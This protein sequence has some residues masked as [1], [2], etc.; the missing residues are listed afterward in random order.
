MRFG[1]ATIVAITAWCSATTSSAF[2]PTYHFSTIRTGRSEQSSHLVPLSFRSASFKKSSLFMSA[3]P[4]DAQATIDAAIAEAGTKG[5]TLFG[6]SACPFCKKTKKALYGIGI[7]AT[8]VE[9]DQV[10]GGPAIQ[11]KLEDVTGKATVPNVWFD[12]KFIG[13]S[14]EVFKGL[15]DGLFDDAEKGEVVVMEDVPKVPVE[16]GEGTIK[17]G[18][19]IPSDLVW[20]VFDN[21]P[22]TYID[23]SEHSK[24]K[25]LIVM[26]LPG[27]FTPT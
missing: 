25:S 1:T 9:L 14:E 7:H 6:K 3:S 10:E 4:F 5:V 26:G 22:A 19:K 15:E 20:S 12:G 11:K 21:D 27:A 17:V 8:I 24:G 18:D 16:Q 23:L 13:G 2:T